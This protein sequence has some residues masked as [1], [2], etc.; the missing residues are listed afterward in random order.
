MKRDSRTTRHMECNSKGADL[1]SLSR[2]QLHLRAKQH[3]TTASGSRSETK[4]MNCQ[5]RQAIPMTMDEVT[6]AAVH[7]IC[8]VPLRI[9]KLGNSI[10]YGTLQKPMVSCTE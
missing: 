6:R 8:D 7:E 3:D 10:A 2:K 1:L 5:A 4:E 9:S